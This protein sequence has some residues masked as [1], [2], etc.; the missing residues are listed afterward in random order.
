MSW[1]PTRDLALQT[2]YGFLKSPE[3]ALPN[4]NQNRATASLLY[5]RDL[6]HDA[7]LASA[8]VYG[9]NATSGTGI[10]RAYT[11]ET[12]LQ[13]QSN[14]VFLRADT[15]KNRAPNSFSTPPM[16]ITSTAS[17]PFRW[18]MC[19]TFRMAK[20]SMSAWACKAPL[21]MAHPV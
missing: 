21:A 2:S 19:A 6:G 9:Q 15:S 1:N 16:R 18:V 10:T 3:E 4:E 17:T 11:V 20:V 13:K 12:A 8:L 5:N 7:N 14:T